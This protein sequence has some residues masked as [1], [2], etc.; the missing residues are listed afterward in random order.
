MGP[1]FVAAGHASSPLRKRRLRPEPQWGPQAVAAGLNTGE[2]VDRSRD[3]EH[4]PV[5]VLRDAVTAGLGF[6]EL[7]RR[8]GKAGNTVAPHALRYLINLR[9]RVRSAVL[10]E[11]VAAWRRLGSHLRIIGAHGVLALSW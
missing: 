2:G 8:G 3:S 1:T 5:T 4:D 10:H 7:Q 6:A 9:H 11:C